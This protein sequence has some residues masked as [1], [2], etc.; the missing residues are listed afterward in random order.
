MKFKITKFGERHFDRKFGGTKILDMT[1]EEVEKHINKLG[2]C[3]DKT[4]KPGD[5]MTSKR[6]NEFIGV[7]V[8]DGY[9]PFCRL[10]AVRN[11]TNARVGSMPITL[12]NWFFIKSGYSARRDSELPVF[13]RWLELPL[14]KPRAEYLMFVLYDKEQIDKE[15]QV[16]YEKEMK[17]IADR[18]GYRTTQPLPPKS[19][20][21][22]WG[23][24]A[25]LGQSH[26]NEEKMQP[27]TML[28]NALGIE[29]GGSGVPLNKEEYLKS[30]D[31]WEKNIIVK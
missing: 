24:V 21:A 9:A 5:V 2:I 17:V 19:F 25:I 20:D 29:E 26:P 15:A 11:F 12:E 1:K 31:F 27:A 18:G 13:S 22:D 28:R 23:V 10:V 14:G 16:D 6:S 3:M 4:N 8:H 30:V 7:K